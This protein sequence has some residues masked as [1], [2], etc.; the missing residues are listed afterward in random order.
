[1]SGDTE[2]RDD[3]ATSSASASRSDERSPRLPV[4]FSVTLEG[5]TIA[6]NAFSVRA[7][8]VRVSR[9][10]GT[11]ITDVDV[12]I[13]ARVF[14]TPPFGS[15]LEAEVNGVWVDEKDGRRRIGVKLLDAEG[16]FAE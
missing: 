6:G 3:R 15:V 10:G 5:Q 16:W 2:D 12:E 1:M 14:L 8:A 13:G 11:I 4:D 9:G 7:V